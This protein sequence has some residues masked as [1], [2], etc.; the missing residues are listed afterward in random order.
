LL[1]KMAFIIPFLILLVSVFLVFFLYVATWSWP[2]FFLISCRL[3]KSPSPP[4]QIQFSEIQSWTT[5]RTRYYQDG[6]N[7]ILIQGVGTIPWQVLWQVLLI[8]N[9][10]ITIR[11]NNIMIL[12]GMNQLGLLITQLKNLR[13]CIWGVISIW[14]IWVN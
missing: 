13:V 2:S 14:R 1:P 9:L 3:Y 10:F 7:N 11:I 8:W 6:S 4:Y 12:F 5:R